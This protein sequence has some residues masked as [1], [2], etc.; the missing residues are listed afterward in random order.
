MCGMDSCA[1]AVCLDGDSSVPLIGEPEPSAP[2]LLPWLLF[3]R[4]S[5]ALVAAPR[6]ACC[7]ANRST[8]ALF[9]GESLEH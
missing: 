4:R 5:L 7:R 1:R 9:P 3:L 6:A 2:V 8:P